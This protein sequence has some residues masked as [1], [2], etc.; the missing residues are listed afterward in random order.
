MDD[1][2]DSAR[3]TRS[4]RAEA[5]RDAKPASDTHKPKA[6]GAEPSGLWARERRRFLM[7]KLHSLSG[8]VPLGLFLLVHLFTN[9]RALGGED[10]FQHAVADINGLPYLLV[11]EIALI[12]APLLFHAGYGVVL[13][14]ES[15][16]NVGRYTGNRNWMYT[17]QRA[18]GVLAFAFIG[19]HLWQFWFQKVSGKMASEQ[20]YGAL[21][22]KLSTPIGG[23]PLTALGYV[24]GIGAVVFHFANGL[25]G[26]CTSWGITPTRRS[27]RISATVFGVLG[28]VVFFLGANT[29]IYFATGSKIAIFGTPSDSALAS[30]RTCPDVLESPKPV[31]PAGVEAA[32]PTDR[33]AEDPLARAR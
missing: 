7:R 20:F 21:C 27:Q 22:E 19:W 5:A 6:R 24:F 18:T 25:W 29:A 11:I 16:P 23:V 13:A 28:A 15:R 31:K 1:E 26:F 12:L 30:V 3:D 10:S 17:A 14:L 32:A 9:A 8:V 2:P 4:S 33:G